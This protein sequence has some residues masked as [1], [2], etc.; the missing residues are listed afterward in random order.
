MS[1]CKQTPRKNVQ[2]VNRPSE[3]TAYVYKCLNGLVRHDM[4]FIRHQ[5]QHNHNIRTEL[6]FRLPGVQRNWGKQGTAFHSIKD[7]NTISQAIR[8]FMSVDIFQHNLLN[9]HF[10]DFR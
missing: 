3:N 9:S 8:S 5:E 4:N 2:L 7:F 10:H 1:V 6:N